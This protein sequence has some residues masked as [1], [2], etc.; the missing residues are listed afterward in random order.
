M[1]WITKSQRVVSKTYS[2][3]NKY[4]TKHWSRRPQRGPP[5]KVVSILVWSKN[6]NESIRLFRRSAKC[7]RK[8]SNRL[9]ISHLQHLNS[10]HRLFRQAGPG[11]EPTLRK[12]RC[13][14]ISSVN[15]PKKLTSRP[16]KRPSEGKNS[17]T[18]NL[19]LIRPRS[20]L[21]TSST[22]PLTR[23]SWLKNK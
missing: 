9:K 19:S 4:F 15:S 17:L 6:R 14:Q 8:R 11:S 16:Q 20:W 7:L 5:G 3:H 23:W 12:R 18:S 13:V 21:V 10:L 1:R 2:S 22:T